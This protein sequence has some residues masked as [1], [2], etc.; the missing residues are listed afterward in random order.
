MV[1]YSTDGLPDYFRPTLHDII[2]SIFR[3]AELAAEMFET[4]KRTEFSGDNAVGLVD[5]RKLNLLLADAKQNGHQD[6]L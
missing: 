6:S 3:E 2:F 5:S 1:D 4:G